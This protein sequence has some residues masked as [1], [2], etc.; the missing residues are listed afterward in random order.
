MNE[1]IVTFRDSENDIQKK[2]IHAESMIDVMYVV[3]KK[4]GEVKIDE[5]AEN[6]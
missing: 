2:K 3:R 5:I 4:Y 6:F 1:Y